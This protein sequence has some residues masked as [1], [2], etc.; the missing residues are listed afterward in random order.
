MFYD[1]FPLHQE[2][3]DDYE[4]VITFGDDPDNDDTLYVQNKST[5]K[6]FQM[7]RVFQPNASQTEVSLFRLH[8][9]RG[10]SKVFT[11]EY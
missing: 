11:W 3:G 10:K 2:D 1:L 6:H 7:D 8:E 5:N 4:Q 9:N